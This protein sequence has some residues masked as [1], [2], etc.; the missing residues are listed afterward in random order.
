[1]HISELGEFTHGNKFVARYAPLEM[2]TEKMYNNRTIPLVRGKFYSFST[3]GN[4]TDAEINHW[5]CGYF[6]GKTN[7]FIDYK[8]I[9]LVSIN[10]T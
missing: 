8:D 6:K 7:G 1:M 2:A 9:T 4:S 10:K 5:C 3:V